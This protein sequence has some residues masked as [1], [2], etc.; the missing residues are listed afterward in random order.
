MYYNY[1]HGQGASWGSWGALVYSTDP[2]SQK[3]DALLSLTRPPADINL[4]GVADG[5]DCVI[6][7]SNL[8]KTGMWREQGDLN[9]DGRVDS[10][11]L[12]VFNSNSSSACN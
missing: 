4:D 7:K 2:G 9:H 1:A 3:W 10:S 12:A 5:S 11:D 6:L 8:G